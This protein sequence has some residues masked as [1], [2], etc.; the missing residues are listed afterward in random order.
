MKS[1]K[2]NPQKAYLAE[3]AQEFTNAYYANNSGQTGN[4]NNID[5]FIWSMY[6]AFQ[7]NTKPSVK[8]FCDCCQ[9][10]VTAKNGHFTQLPYQETKNW[11]KKMVKLAKSMIFWI[12][13]GRQGIPSALDK[14]PRNTA[15]RQDINNTADKISNLSTDTIGALVVEISRNKLQSS[16]ENVTQ[17]C[18][19]NYWVM[20]ERIVVDY[21]Y[22]D[23]LNFAT[24]VHQRSSKI[25]KD[26]LLKELKKCCTSKQDIDYRQFARQAYPTT[27]L[28]PFEFGLYYSEVTESVVFL[29]AN[30]VTRSAIEKEIEDTITSI[31]T[32]KLGTDCSGRLAQFYRTFNDKPA[33]WEVQEPCFDSRQYLPQQSQPTPQQYQ[34][35]PQ[36]PKQAQPKFHESQNGIAD[37]LYQQIKQSP[38]YNQD[39]C[40]VDFRVITPPRKSLSKQTAQRVVTLLWDMLVPYNHPLTPDLRYLVAKTEAAPNA[41]IFDEK[42]RV[43]PKHPA[44]T[45]F[46]HVS[47]TL[48]SKVISTLQFRGGQCTEEF[49][50][51]QKDIY[52][53]ENG[54]RKLM[55]IVHDEC[56]WGIEKNNQVDILF[57]GAIHTSGEKPN[58]CNPLCEPNVFIVHVSATGWNFDVKAVNHNVIAWKTIP[59]GYTSQESYATG[60]N[61][62]QHLHVDNA[63]DRMVSSLQIKFKDSR[64]KKYIP[65]IALIVEYILAYVRI[66]LPDDASFYGQPGATCAETSKE[67]LWLFRHFTDYKDQGYSDCPTVL[68]RIQKGGLQNIFIKWLKVIR[69]LLPNHGISKFKIASPSSNQSELNM[70]NSFEN[71]EINMHPTIVVVI[72][73]AKMGDTLPNLSAFDLRARYGKETSCYSSFVQDAGRCFGFR[74]TP[75]TMILNRLGCYILC[76]FTSKVD[77]FLERTTDPVR[78]IPQIAKFSRLGDNMLLPGRESMWNRVLMANDENVLCHVRENRFLLQARP[79]IGKTGA[80]LKLI[81]LLFEDQYSLPESVVYGKYPLWGSE[82]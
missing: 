25:D 65:T 31:L 18:K 75:P 17:F 29:F 52:T 51:L 57:N 73:K 6:H 79:Q 22:I 62:D 5:P 60:I 53:E 46:E 64:I 69:S 38:N 8:D 80:F 70:D 20:F 59:P 30:C 3:V 74:K 71:S 33:S 9:N 50:Q 56:H 27:Q 48:K 13:H 43:D 4:S 1:T 16:D 55:L 24:E 58:P 82:V 66:A 40:G 72:E 37:E 39:F 7:N 42:T 68:I 15:A 28:K 81:R 76:G 67:T 61:K 21:T 44:W 10:E 23:I 54:R 14:Q 2:S 34:P 45:L 47:R 19:Q 32:E 41:S 35:P 63:F 36:Q 11:S 77:R 26:H 78:D 12:Q 49:L